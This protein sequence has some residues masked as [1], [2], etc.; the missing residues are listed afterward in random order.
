M[1]TSTKLG[2]EFLRIPKLEVSGANWVIYKDRFTLALDAHC[3]LDHIDG[4]GKEPTDPIAEEDRTAKKA[5]TAEQKILETEWK[6][7]M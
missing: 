3:I 4:T 7:E 6:K 5:L 2:D 1:S